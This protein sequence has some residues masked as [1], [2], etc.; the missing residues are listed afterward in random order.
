MGIYTFDSEAPNVV[1]N[2]SLFASREHF[3]S[4]CGSLLLHEDV[5]GKHFY[6]LCGEYNGR[7]TKLM[8]STQWRVGTRVRRASVTAART[9]GKYEG[10]G[11]AKEQREEEDQI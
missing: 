5:T 4:S 11:S 6:S 10:G 1:W 9:T 2:V 8:G 7:T 3:P